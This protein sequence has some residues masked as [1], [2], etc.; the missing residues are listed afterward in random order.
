MTAR[1]W[2]APLF[3]LL[4]LG[5]QREEPSPELQAPPVAVAP[6]QSVDLEERIEATG[7]LIARQHAEIAAEVGG[8]VTEVVVAEGTPVE[9]G[10]IVIEID[11]KR[12]ELELIGARAAVAEARAGLAEQERETERQRSLFR[13]NVSAKAQLE[14]AETQL[15]LAR[16]RLEGA[17]A[18]LGVAE[19]ALSDASVQAPFAGLVARRFVSEGEF[20]QPG[21]RLFELVSLDPIEVEFFLAERDSSRVQLG[22]VVGVQVAPYPDEVFP[23]AVSYISPTIDPRTRTLRVK[24]D[25]GNREGRLRPGLFA[26]ADLGLAVRN[27]VLMVP[28]EAVLQRSDGSVVFRLRDGNRVERRVIELGTMR[29][30]SVEIQSGVESGDL[31]VVR[32]HSALVDGAAVV[33]RTLDGSLVRPP[34]ASRFDQSKLLR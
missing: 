4:A 31:V 14:Q 13:R 15:E 28:E 8:R 30:G 23:A 19:R 26:R 27:G 2:L 34:V 24:A 29:R 18:R 5:C 11:P 16:S 10:T 25:V 22:Q 12:R 7:Q 32:G 20:V 33:V 1:L 21:K 9:T 6:V 3:A 17:R